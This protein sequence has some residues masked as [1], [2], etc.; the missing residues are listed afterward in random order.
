MTLDVLTTL[1]GWTLIINLGV[2]LFST[3][4]LILLGSWAARIHKKMFEIDTASLQKI[5]F[6]YLAQYKLL[7]VIFNLAPYLALR[8]MNS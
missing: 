1:L 5:Y 6:Q 4:L 2:L 7:F 8:I 3:L